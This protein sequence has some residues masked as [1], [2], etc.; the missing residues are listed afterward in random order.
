MTSPRAQAQT[1]ALKTNAV[2]IQGEY[3]ILPIHPADVG[4]IQIGVHGSAD[5]MGD[6]KAESEEEGHEQEKDPE[7]LPVVDGAAQG[8]RAPETGAARSSVTMVRRKGAQDAF[9]SGRG[10]IENAGMGDNMR[11]RGRCVIETTDVADNWAKGVVENV[12]VG[13]E[14]AREIRV[15]Q[16]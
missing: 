15:R 6:A 9:R 14:R 3:R 16:R 4:V 1:N 8:A 11:A 12:G 13:D 5:L 7:Q 2:M 10:L